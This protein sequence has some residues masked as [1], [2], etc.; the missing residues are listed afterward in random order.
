MVSQH[1]FDLVGP[2]TGVPQLNMTRNCSRQHTYLGSESK[3]DVPK[4]TCQGSDTSYVLRVCG[5]HP[6]LTTIH[7]PRLLRWHTRT[8]HSFRP[9]DRS[10]GLTLSHVAKCL[11]L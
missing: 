6:D 2:P 4:V 1:E 5:S 7:R 8:M 11:R 9:I 3:G 10:A